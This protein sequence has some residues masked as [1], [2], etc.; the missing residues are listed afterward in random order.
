MR[1]EARM[2]QTDMF[3]RLLALMATRFTPCPKFPLWY[4][5]L[6]IRNVLDSTILVWPMQL[7]Q[8]ASWTGQCQGH[9]KS[10]QKWKRELEWR[11][12]GEKL[13][14]K[15][16]NLLALFNV[17]VLH[18]FFFFISGFGVSLLLVF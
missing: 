7:G 14:A 18:F 6:Q 3:G 11:E 2:Q 15:V 4:H 8:N 10:C 12:C 13:H 1:E 5:V 17:C 16:G 9:A